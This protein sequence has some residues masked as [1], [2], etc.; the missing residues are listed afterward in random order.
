L[1]ASKSPW[2]ALLTKKV[3]DD[4]SGMF[5]ELMAQSSSAGTSKAGFL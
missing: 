2:T 5:L 3:S 1:K 4:G